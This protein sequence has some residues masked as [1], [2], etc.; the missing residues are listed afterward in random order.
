MVRRQGV[1]ISPI[2]PP[3]PKANVSSLLIAMHASLA[4]PA[5]WRSHSRPAR[6]FGGTVSS[7]I[8][9]SCGAPRRQGDYG[10]VQECGLFGD[11]VGASGDRRTPTGRRQSVC[12]RSPYKQ[13]TIKPPPS[14]RE[15]WQCAHGERRHDAGPAAT[16]TVWRSQLN[17]SSTRQGDHRCKRQG[18]RQVGTTNV[19]NHRLITPSP[20]SCCGRCDKSLSAKWG[21]SANQARPWGG[22]F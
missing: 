8:P 5:W 3:A 22:L 13:T 21:P 16:T 10:C 9:C 7:R 1:A 20:R 14:G 15:A 19:G 18:C 11:E 4:I 6:A 2:M 12:Q 17:V